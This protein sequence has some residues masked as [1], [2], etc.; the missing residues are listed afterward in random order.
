MH[1]LLAVGGVKVPHSYGPETRDKVANDQ[2]HIDY[3]DV[4]PS[5]SN[6][7]I[8]LILRDNHSSYY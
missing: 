5:V 3:I 4:A 8:I 2:L 6:K 7:P 1:F